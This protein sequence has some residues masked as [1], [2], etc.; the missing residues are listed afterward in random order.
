MPTPN[1]GALAGFLGH[2]DAIDIYDKGYMRFRYRNYSLFEGNSKLQAN[3]QKW[4]RICVAQTPA[5]IVNNHDFVTEFGVSLS[6][7]RQRK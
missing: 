3:I 7:N 6:L 4:F 1:V 5:L 2:K